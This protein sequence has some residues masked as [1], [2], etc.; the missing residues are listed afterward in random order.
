MF[1]K[2][3]VCC[4]KICLAKNVIYVKMYGDDLSGNYC[5]RCLK[6]YMIS[7]IMDFKEYVNSSRFRSDPKFI[8]KLQ[9]VKKILQI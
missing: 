7:S 3:C 9:E 5:F 2:R 8:E 1:I 6:A 4:R